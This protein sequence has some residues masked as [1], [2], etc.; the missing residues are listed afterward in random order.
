MQEVATLDKL[1]QE[2]ERK[3]KRNTDSSHIQNVTGLGF[4]NVAFPFAALV[5]GFIMSF[6]QLGM[7]AILF[8]KN[9]PKDG[10]I[11]TKDNDGISEEAEDMIEEINDLLLDKHSKRKDIQ[12]LF[13]IRTLA[14]SD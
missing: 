13:K 4:E 7:E 5:I 10:V 1:R 2:I 6:V 14:F 12:L 9:R 11:Q 3:H 8:F